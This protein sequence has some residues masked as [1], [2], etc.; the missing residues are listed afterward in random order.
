MTRG[1]EHRPE[2]VPKRTKDPRR[3][4]GD[5]LYDFSEDPPQMRWGVHEEANRKTDLSGGYALLSEYFF[6]FGDQP[7]TLPEYLRGIVCQRGHRSDSNDP[8]LEPFLD[9]LFGLGLEPNGLYGKPRKGPLSR[10]V[11]GCGIRRR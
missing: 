7:C 8:Y 4:V 2:K 3:W 6:Y 11:I 1:Q 5:A 10:T 9:W